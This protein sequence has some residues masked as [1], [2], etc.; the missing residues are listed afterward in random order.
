MEFLL[1][2]FILKIRNYRIGEISLV[3]SG[4]EYHLY[5]H[6][7]PR[8]LDASILKT[9]LPVHR[10]YDIEQ[11]EVKHAGKKVP[12]EKKTPIIEMMPIAEPVISVDSA[13]KVVL[14][15]DTYALKMN[16]LDV[17]FREYKSKRLGRAL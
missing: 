6:N 16:K 4:D 13:L 1:N 15:R 8:A 14:N 3:R 2:A 5:L 10:G 9:K 17:L 11:V 7:I 12:R